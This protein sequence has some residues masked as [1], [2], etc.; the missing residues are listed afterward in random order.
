MRKERN[1]NINIPC[2]HWTRSLV[3]YF[4]YTISFLHHR[5]PF[6]SFISISVPYSVYEI[7]TVEFYIWIRSPCSNVSIYGK[8]EKLTNKG[9]GQ[10]TF[11]GRVNSR[12]PFSYL[13]LFFYWIFRKIFKSRIVITRGYFHISQKTK[14][15]LG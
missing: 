13:V 8:T 11:S 1:N 15:F 9:I 6:R 5:H 12:V 3:T 2:M 10:S 7:K 14:S 4:L